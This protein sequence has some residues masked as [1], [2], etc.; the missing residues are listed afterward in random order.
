MEK[1]VHL[2]ALT[3][4][5]V[6]ICGFEAQRCGKRVQVNHHTVES[7]QRYLV[8]LYRRAWGTYSP[9]VCMR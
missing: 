7:L 3:S 5:W 6:D 9:D 1:P 8:L 2:L 4:E